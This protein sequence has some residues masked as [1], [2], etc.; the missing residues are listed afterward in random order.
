MSV[1][2]IV[3]EQEALSDWKP[4]LSLITLYSGDVLEANR[5]LA[6]CMQLCLKMQSHTVAAVVCAYLAETALWQ[7]E[8]DQAQQWLKQSLD[9]EA[10][11]TRISF[12]TV[13]R[14]WVAARI[15]T[16]QQQY[17]RAATLF[18]LAEQAH[19]QIHHVIGGP[20]R[21]LADTALATVQAML[22]PAAFA[23][24]FAAG[25][26]MSL[27]EMFAMLLGWNRFNA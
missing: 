20:M 9:Y 12:D 11:P 27:A 25:Q 16:A 19:S 14:C 1:N 18:S 24:A 6:E 22:E 26:A 2:T 21:A 3:N 8:L 7:G 15:A 10:K 4:L 13:Q 17:Q 5:L 23:E